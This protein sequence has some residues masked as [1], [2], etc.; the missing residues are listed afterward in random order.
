[1]KR[2]IKSTTDDTP[3]VDDIWMAIPKEY[4]PYI[5]EVTIVPQHSAHRNKDIITYNAIFKNSVWERDHNPV[6]GIL[7]A[8]DVPTLVKGVVDHLNTKFPEIKHK[9]IDR[10]HPKRN[11]GW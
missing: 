3:T 2:Y 9:V 5:D 10:W 8:E 4:R 1:M 7:Y 6:V 11:R